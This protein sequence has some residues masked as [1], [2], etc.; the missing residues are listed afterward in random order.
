MNIQW[1]NIYQSLVMKKKLST[2]KNAEAYITLS[3][4]NMRIRKQFSFRSK[5]LTVQDILFIARQS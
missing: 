3:T 2:D 5:K 4:S 1:H